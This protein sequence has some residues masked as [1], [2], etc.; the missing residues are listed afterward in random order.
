[1]GATDCVW[2]TG[3]AGYL[4]PAP[5][6]CDT[7]VRVAEIG[8]AE[9]ERRQHPRLRLVELSLLGDLER[10]RSLIAAVQIPT[11]VFERVG[12]GR[13]HRHLEVGSGVFGQRGLRV[14]VCGH[15]VPTS[16]GG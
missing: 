7:S 12:I 15:R 2:V 8:D 5:H 14:R 11:E 16:S 13:Q 6:Q 10:G 1:M 4:H 9:P 3:V